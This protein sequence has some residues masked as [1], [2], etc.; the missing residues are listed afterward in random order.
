MARTTVVES[1]FTKLWPGLET[2]S[3]YQS[4]TLGFRLGCRG[5][6]PPAGVEGPQAPATGYGWGGD[7]PAILLLTLFW[8]SRRKAL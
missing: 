5:L 2:G 1:F 7:P 3:G 4:G 6:R 8:E